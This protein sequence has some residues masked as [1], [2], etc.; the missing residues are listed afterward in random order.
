[1]PVKHPKPLDL[2]VA[3]NPLHDPLL[4]FNLPLEQA[5]M[6]RAEGERDR[7]K[8]FKLFATLDDEHSPAR[9]S[10]IWL[11]HPARAVEDLRRKPHALLKRMRLRMRKAQLCDQCRKAKLVR[12]G[13]GGPPAGAMLF[14]P[15]VVE[16]QEAGRYAAEDVTARIPFTCCDRT[17]SSTAGTSN[18]STVKLLSALECPGAERC[19]P[20]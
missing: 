2:P 5:R 17:I 20:P 11:N 4:P 1:M 19:H 15:S 8:P 10:A 16:I 3:Q 6:G 14:K 7:V 12:K 13:V 9:P 18:G